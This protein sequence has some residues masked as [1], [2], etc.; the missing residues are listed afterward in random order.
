MKTASIHC[1]SLNHENN[2]L[3]MHIILF[4]C[5][6]HTTIIAS[7]FLRLNF[8]WSPVVI[9]WLNAIKPQQ[10][11]SNAKQTLYATFNAHVRIDS[12]HIN[13]IECE[14]NTLFI[15]LLFIFS[16][17]TATFF[18]MQL[19]CCWLVKRMILE[20]VIICWGYF[21]TVRCMFETL[22]K[23]RIK[24]TSKH[25]TQWWLSNFFCCCG[26]CLSHCIS[27]LW[28]NPFEVTKLSFLICQASADVNVSL[29]NCI[30]NVSI[31]CLFVAWMVSFIPYTY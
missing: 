13:L 24:M 20:L 7:I 9:R 5:H 8:F 14:L 28:M 30:G 17:T 27:L 21:S 2:H 6:H 19:F 4:V 16:L 25:Y 3:T 1:N 22:D 31:F 11:L 12:L 18:F 26:C 23:F 10:M 15:A 29:W